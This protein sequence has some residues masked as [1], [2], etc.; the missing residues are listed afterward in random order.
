MTGMSRRA[1]AWE[2][3]NSVREQPE[4]QWETGFAPPG[5]RPDRRA[6]DQINEQRTLR[7]YTAQPWPGLKE[8][9]RRTLTQHQILPEYAD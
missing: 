5:S 7:K 6:G 8:P 9:A 3:E 2:W 1:F 4:R